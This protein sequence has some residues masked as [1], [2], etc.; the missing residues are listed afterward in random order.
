MPWPLPLEQRSLIF[1]FGDVLAYSGDVETQ[2]I[3][4]R[5]DIP[6]GQQTYRAVKVK[7]ILLVTNDQKK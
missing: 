4:R 7:L 2:T 5:L 6:T 3:G 1:E